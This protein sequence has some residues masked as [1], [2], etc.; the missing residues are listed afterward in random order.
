[1]YEPG[2]APHSSFAH[3]A[4]RVDRADLMRLPWVLAAVEIIEPRP[5]DQCRRP[6]PR[7]R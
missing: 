1:V 2:L 4:L 6:A 3:H 7:A 5:A